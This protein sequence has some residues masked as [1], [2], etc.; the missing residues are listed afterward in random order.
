MPVGN[1]VEPILPES[2]TDFKLL[3]S[4]EKSIPK[5]KMNLSIND[6][7]PKIKKIKDPFWQ[8]IACLTIIKALPENKKLSCSELDASLDVRDLMKDQFLKAKAN[9]EIETRKPTFE[10]SSPFPEPGQEY[11]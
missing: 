3:A 5:I 7:C 8:S 10:I 4:I 11:N 1:G 2:L 9:D 6:D